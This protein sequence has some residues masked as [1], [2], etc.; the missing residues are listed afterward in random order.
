[1]VDERAAF[2][3]T[4]AGKNKSSVD[5]GSH[6]AAGIKSGLRASPAVVGD[7]YSVCVRRRHTAVRPAVPVQQKVTSCRRIAPAAH[8]ISASAGKLWSRGRYAERFLDV[9]LKR[10]KK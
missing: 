10:G 8:D 1:M 9:L 6:H 3:R 4:S 7:E 2:T 5:L